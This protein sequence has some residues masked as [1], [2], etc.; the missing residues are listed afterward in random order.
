[1]K[2][3]TLLI[4]LTF[5]MASC[6]KNKSPENLPR[7]KEAFKQQV[8]SFEKNKVAT[9]TNVTKGLES[10]NGLKTSLE[11]AKNEDKEFAKVYGNWEKVDNKVK[12][13]TK[14]YEDLK[15]KAE[16]LFKAMEEQSNSLADQKSKADLL[17]AISSTRKKYNV[18]LV[19]T[20]KAIEKLRALHGDAVDV[21]KALEVAVALNSFDDINAQLKSIEGRVDGIMQ[22][23]NVAVEESKKLYDK[24]LDQVK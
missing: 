9:N 17:A 10:L 7:L 4:S 18:T 5:L 13:L 2:K 22:E 20:S 11:G 16:N 14:E 21:V 12:S 24:R 19:N 23:L 15:T 8:E 6:W 1:M 3:I